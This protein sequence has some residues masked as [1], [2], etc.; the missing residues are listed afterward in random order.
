[1]E[2]GRTKCGRLSGFW[3]NPI[4]K[5]PKFKRFLLELDALCFSEF[6]CIAQQIKVFNG[7]VIADTLVS[8]RFANEYQNLVFWPSAERTG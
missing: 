2:S 7:A 1:M 4:Q 5:F 6:I 8:P 3:M